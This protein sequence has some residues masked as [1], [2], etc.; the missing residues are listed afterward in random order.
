[1]KRRKGI[2]ALIAATAG[3]GIAAIPAAAELHSVT[4]VLITGER[5]QATVDVPPGTPVSQVQ[6]PGITGTIKQVIDNGADRHA[7]ADSRRRRCPCRP[8]PPRPRTPTPTSTPTPDGNEKPGAPNRT[9]GDS[10]PGQ[11]HART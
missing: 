6:I 9:Q 3:L 4:V 1:M 11:F 8:S 10:E 5:I 2:I 7:D